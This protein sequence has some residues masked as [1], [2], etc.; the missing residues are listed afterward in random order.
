MKDNVELRNL[1]WKRL[2]TDRWFW[3]LFGGGLLLGLCGYVVQAVLGGILVQLEVQSWTDYLSAVLR[4]RQN[5]T[6]PIPNL[7]Q[8][9]VFQAT[10]STVLTAFFSLLMNG[11]VSYGA[12]VILKR[13]LANYGKGWLGEAFGGFRFPFGMTWLQFRFCLIWTGWLIVALAVPGVLFGVGYSLLGDL[14]SLRLALV[15][16]LCVTVGLCWMIWIYCIP[17]YRYRFLFLVKAE[18]PEWGAGQCIAFC[19]KLMKGNMLKSFK[20]DCS[21]WKSITLML[22][23]LLVLSLTILLNECYFGE[24]K[25]GL[26]IIA[27]VALFCLIVFL[28]LSLIVP[29]YIS[30]GQ[31]FLYEELKKLFDRL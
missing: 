26:A 13:C 11:I 28:P 7:T 2:W 6:T 29:Q 30:V 31:G 16:G 1:A 9:Y 23:P 22:L 25:Q 18:H 19:R 27:P 15:A 17:F 10:S 8:G 4:N 12:A 20:L 24:G 3:R 14:S 5:L 21:Y